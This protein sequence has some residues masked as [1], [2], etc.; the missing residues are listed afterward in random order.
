MGEDTTVRL[1]DRFVLRG[2]GFPVDMLDRLRSPRTAGATAELLAARAALDVLAADV[3][4]TMAATGRT[5]KDTGDQ[6]TVTAV[7]RIRKAI[8][9]RRPVD[10][11][12][13]EWA[14]ACTRVAAAEATVAAVYQEELHRG[15]AVLRELFRR[16]DVQEALWLS[17]PDMADAHWP[18]YLK[19]WRPDQR[20]SR[21]KRLER[22]LYT[23]LQRFATK[24]DTTSFFGPL[25][26]GAFL[27]N[28]PPEL[29]IS[30]Q[31]I[32][33]RRGFF[34]FWAAEA[35]A[36]HH[37]DPSSL[38]PLD[39]IGS[40]R[41]DGLRRMVEEFATAPLARRRELLAAAETEYG[42][43][44]G[45]AVRRG[46]D[47]KMFRDRALI[48]EE[49]LGDVE[50]L[51][52]TEVDQDRIATALTPVARLCAE[53]SRRRTNDLR[54]AGNAV[55]STLSPNGAPVPFPRFA[56]AWQRRHPD[57]PPTPSADRLITDL[58]AL[59]SMRRTGA[60]ARLTDAD[61]AAL[62][63]TP[64]DPVVMSPDLMLAADGFDALAKGD[65]RIVVG[66]IH[67]GV[68]PT[69]WMLTFADDPDGWRQATEAM[70][71]QPGTVQPANLV[72]GRR[73]KVAPPRFPGPSVPARDG[74][75]H[76]VVLP[77]PEL[78]APGA[79]RPLRFHPPSHGVGHRYGVFACFS[80][81][82]ADLPRVRTGENTPRIVAGDVVVQRRRWAI[83][84]DRLPSGSSHHLFVACA[85]FRA[86]H[87]LPERVFVRSASEP[88][89]VFVDFSSVFSLEVLAQLGA[90]ATRQNLAEL[91]FEEVL[92][93]MEE[94]WLRRGD[95]RYCTEL[96][97]VC[98]VPGDGVA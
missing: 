37:L 94:L 18:S 26:Y 43:I 85:A 6:A 1:M 29:R 63:V 69:G 71:P 21:I 56:A 28:T 13:P 57:A 35:I 24:N 27:K 41:A 78:R 59:V 64:G 86:E 15:R 14:A 34:A 10:G 61:V 38:T 51:H 68:Q 8:A 12:P 90:D 98:T 49:C 66:E 7:R 44:T 60:E 11:A 42:R 65:Y 97:T 84:A 9:A 81:P 50:R 16:D 70:L 62:C 3:D 67:H 95:G 5:A 48:Y 89:P 93:D 92:P 23:Y 53:Y 4:R 52:L 74:L 2:T 19:H 80:Y 79:D 39:D 54:A 46:G 25:N 55:L 88:K 36:G 77:G 22:I 40:P 73:M 30:S 72:L 31:R 32:R 83:P 75:S 91:L 33:A 82:L 76:L 17:N 58:T 96:R 20:D 45:D 47:G 87:R